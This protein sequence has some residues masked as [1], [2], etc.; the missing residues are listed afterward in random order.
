MS[1]MEKVGEPGKP[2][3]RDFFDLKKEKKRF[4]SQHIDIAV[5]KLVILCFWYLKN[6][7][8][9]KNISGFRIRGNALCNLL[10]VQIF[11]AVFRNRYCINGIHPLTATR[12]I[13]PSTW[14]LDIALWDNYKAMR[15]LLFLSRNFDLN[16]VQ[17][18]P[19]SHEDH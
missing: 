2:S 4:F 5:L 16:R 1:P 17:L 3:S 7:S 18:T 12:W 9:Y 14:Q 15:T 13:M 10:I 8:W 19:K 11:W 6:L